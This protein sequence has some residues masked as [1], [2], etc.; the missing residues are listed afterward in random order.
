MN[1]EPSRPASSPACQT[2]TTDRFGRGPFA[3][4]L[5]MPSS[6]VDPDP[7]SSAPFRSVSGGAGPAARRVRAARAIPDVIEVR[8]EEHVRVLELGIR[9]FDHADDVLGEL[10]R[11]HIEGVVDVTVTFTSASENGGSASPL[12]ARAGRSA[13]FVD[14]C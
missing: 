2:K 5:A 13:N 1:C 11:G 7:S 8:A 6:A 10:R 3:N 9:A 12:M 4:A 14:E